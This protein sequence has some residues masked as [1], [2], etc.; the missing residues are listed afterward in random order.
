MRYVV[1]IYSNP[2]TW[3]HPM[4]LHQHEQ[5]APEEADLRMGEFTALM[6]EISES[7]E[8]VDATPL[9][10]PVTARSIRTRE[11]AGGEG[12]GGALTPAALQ[13]PERGVPDTRPPWLTRAPAR[14]PAAPRRSEVARHRREA[15]VAALTPADEL[16]APA[17]DE[18]EE[19]G[20]DTL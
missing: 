4:F 5:L 12:A 15:T 2:A 1:M 9:A 10:D 3:V 17:A 6:K 18:D 20:D 16:L 7:G 13:G 11:G 8:L 19:H 14:R